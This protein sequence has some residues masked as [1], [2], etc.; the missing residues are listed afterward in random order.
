MASSWKAIA[1]E[2]GRVLSSSRAACLV[3]AHSPGKSL[4]SF[5]LVPQM[6]TEGRLRSLVTMALTSRSTA[7]CQAAMLLTLCQPGASSQTSRPSSSQ[8]SRK[9]GDCG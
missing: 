1:P 8:A 3:A 5:S 6:I 2:L 7:S 9:A 4:V